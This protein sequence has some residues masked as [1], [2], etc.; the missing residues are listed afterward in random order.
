MTDPSQPGQPV[1]PETD[2]S[3]NMTN[4]AP[5]EGSRV[6]ANLRDML[7]QLQSMIDTVA[8]QAGPMLR[9]V[10]AKAAELAA[11]AGEHAGP[12]AYK[13]AEKTQSVGRRV[14]ERGKEV[15]ADLRR[16][17]AAEADAGAMPVGDMPD[18]DASATQ[19]AESAAPEMEAADEMPAEKG[20]GED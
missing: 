5:S 4:A 2:D 9:E 7:V 19:T 13:A 14:A 6:Q 1:G 3:Q 8:V 10:A 16:P 11:V 12:L 17:Q 20:W 15:A 18:A